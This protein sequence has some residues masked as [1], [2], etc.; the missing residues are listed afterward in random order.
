MN[1]RFTSLTIVISAL[2]LGVPLVYGQEGVPDPLSPTVQPLQT[3]AQAEPKNVLSFGLVV[4]SVFDDNALGDN[5]DKKSDFQETIEPS[6]RFQQHLP[7]LDWGFHYRPGVSFSQRFASN[8]SF[9]QEGGADVAYKFSRRLFIKASEAS[10]ISTNPFQQLGATSGLGVLDRP[11]P[12]IILPRVRQIANN[13]SLEIMYLLGRH[14]SVSVTGSFSDSHYHNL[15]GTG[16]DTLRLIDTRTVHGRSTLSH[17][18][19]RRESAGVFVDYQDLS[20][21]RA[22][23]RTQTENFSLF[24]EF[25]ITPHMSLTVFGGPDHTRIHDQVV[26]NLSFFTISLPVFRTQW[27]GSGGVEYR[28]KRPHDAVHASFVRKISD[29]GGLVGSVNL[30]D[31]NVEYVRNLTKS[32]TAT[33]GGDYATNT[34]LGFNGQ[35]KLIVYQGKLGLSRQIS[36][37]IV[38]NLQYNRGHQSQSGAVAGALV[39]DHD[40]AAITILYQFTRP[41]GR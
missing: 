24:N 28:W 37:D 5:R 1:A 39:Q 31:G 22:H 11:N 35:S 36:Q 17:Q 20:F 16:T 27:S 12:T 21:P 38:L 6:I 30:T 18:F 2:F 10:A 4:G 13:G 34:S 40:R 26:V 19:S 25:D 8:D 33:V 29:G 7:T 14:T 32:W 9:R 41:I 23:A 3:E 15:L